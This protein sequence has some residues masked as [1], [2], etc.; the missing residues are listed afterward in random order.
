MKKA[1]KKKLNNVCAEVAKILNRKRQSVW[2]HYEILKK[3]HN[4]PHS[5]NNSI[6]YKSEIESQDESN[7]QEKKEYKH[8]KEHI[9]IHSFRKSIEKTS[10]YIIILMLNI[11][12][13]VFN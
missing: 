7:Y 13:I 12:I 8:K 4:L 2:H 11:E 6:K 9:P 1:P 5:K 10:L 3:K